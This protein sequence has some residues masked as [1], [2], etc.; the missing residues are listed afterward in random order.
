MLGAVL[1]TIGF[2]VLAGL[3]VT[4]MVTPAIAVTSVTVKGG[5][6]IFDNLPS[7]IRI[8]KLPQQN[9]IFANQGGKQVQIATIFS[10]NRQEVAWDEV[11]V[12]AKNAA[13][14]GEDR[15]FYQHGG[16]DPTGVV[17][18]AISTL[19]GG[20]KQGASTIAQQLVKNIFIQQALQL[21]T[22]KQQQ[23]GIEAAQAFT[24]DRKLK[25]MKLAIA[26]EKKYTKQ[27]I[28]L[29]YLN[30]AGFGGNTYGIQAA[31]ER[32]YNTSA[33]NLTIA[34][35]ASLIAI[36]QQPSARA[37]IDASGYAQNKARR[38]VILEAEYLAKHITKA[39]LDEAL[40]T[41]VDAT[42]V[43][44]TDPKNGC[45]AA[46]Q[47][48][49]FFCDYIV[50]AA[51]P[52][53][54]ALGS[55]TSERLANW[56]KGGY[57]IHTT[58]NLS[59]QTTAQKIMWATVPRSPSEL[60]LGGASVSVEAGTGR[61][62]LMTENKYFNNTASPKKGSTAVNYSVDVA[63]GGGVGFQV[64]STYKPFTLIAWLKAGHGLNE[65][66]DATP[67]VQNLS[68]FKDTCDG[69]TY[70]YGGTW[71][72]KN[73]EGERGPYTVMRGTAGS[74]N[75]VFVNMGKQL[76]QCDIYNVAQSLGVHTGDNAPLTHNP[77]AILGTNNIAPL[78][79]AAAYAGIANK[80][81][82][83]APIAVDYV[84][85]PYGKQQ[86]GQTKNCH[87]AIDPDV[88]AAATL[89]MQGV[90][91]GGTGTPG[92]P[93]DGTPL[94]GKT[95]TTDS[96]VHTWIVGASTKVATAVWI[97]NVSGHVAL[98]S[99]YLPQGP[100]ALLRHVVF[101]QTMA[102]IDKKYKGGSFPTPPPSFL[103]GSGQKMPD[104]TGKTISE[105]TVTLQALGFG[106]K[107]GPSVDSALPAGTVAKT[108]PGAGALLST[109]YTVLISPSNQKLLLVPP[110]VGMLE[111]DAVK[112]LNDAGFT[113]IQET[114]QAS[115]PP[116]PTTDN[117]VVSQTPA[118]GSTHTAKATIQLTITRV[119]C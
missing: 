69:G 66:V 105:A 26:L 60:K 39:Q 52:S 68:D 59:L 15:R 44:L 63:A 9:R 14:D 43:H 88:D 117:T 114:C 76:D 23:A 113:D 1:G 51:V 42:T 87:S 7:Y 81:V 45:I 40:A 28:L 54:S 94:I 90:M 96:S 73:D 21:P 53:L 13:V 47:Y 16:I 34:Q 55:K 17:R 85:D 98:R 62:L 78:T 102:A 30:I 10:Q 46:N 25:E 109:G 95:G 5:I 20:Q 37:P 48:A 97:G 22:L 79:M 83:C 82:Y 36:V 118:A 103:S 106:V 38:D 64:G 77:G 75:G 107:V 112:S 92:N 35:G 41:P 12:N 31:A 24:L 99:V 100:A 89:A 2:S 65:V 86:P 111:P 72:Y 58:L 84:V 18:A 11:S 19:S 80:G 71:T 4:A 74:V 101:K 56:A 108:S 116:D 93:N 49:K 29:A 8:D 50:R 104:L 67:Q 119:H 6:G 33:K 57:D 70:P 27:Q 61:I 3:L 91:N 110:V 115:T 32:Y